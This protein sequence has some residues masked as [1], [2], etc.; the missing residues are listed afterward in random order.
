MLMV[1][2]PLPERSAFGVVASAKMSVVWAERRKLATRR[3]GAQ[4]ESFT[5]GSKELTV[6]HRMGGKV[7][8]GL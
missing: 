5:E 7:L 4:R 1:E 2:E 6:V 8:F 3:L